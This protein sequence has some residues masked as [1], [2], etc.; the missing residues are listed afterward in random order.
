MTYRLQLFE[1]SERLVVLDA[2]KKEE[3]ADGVRS[4]TF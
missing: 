3:E 4:L 1:V 2:E